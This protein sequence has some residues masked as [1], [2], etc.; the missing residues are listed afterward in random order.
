VIGIATTVQSLL[1]SRKNATNQNAEIQRRGLG[2][3]PPGRGD[4]PIWMAGALWFVSTCGYVTITHYLVPKFPIW[5]VCG[6]AF[7]YSPIISYV[8]ARLIGL[9]TRGIGFPMIREA[10]IIKSGYKGLDI[11]YADM[12]M[13]DYGG[14]AQW[15]REVELTGTKIT[16]L[17]KMNLFMIPLV[18]ISSFVFWSFFWH[19][20]VIPSAQF[21]YVQQFWPRDATMSAVWMTANKGAN[22]PFM[23]AIKPNVIYAGGALAFLLFGASLAFKIPVLYYYGF[24]GGIGGL[25]HG[26][27]PQLFGALMGRYYFTKRLGAENWS[28]Y[29]PVLL[30]GFACGMGLVGL[31]GIA[32]ALI[33]K[34]TNFL[35]F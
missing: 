4:I 11:W 28:K 26:A 32:M 19:T 9:T 6:F 31:A 1:E 16:S 34:V 23:R 5:I 14:Y 10:V 13:R 29:T 18:L 3:P 2:D 24:I 15:L 17:I 20:N 30:A 8:S 27:I 22:S 21:P 33:V 12:G 25:P 35:P 7:F